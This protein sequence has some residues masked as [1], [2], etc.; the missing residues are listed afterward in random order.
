M[1][2]YK[3]EDNKWNAKVAMIESHMESN[4]V[5]DMAA[6]LQWNL[7]QGTNDTDN[8]KRYWSNI[9]NMFATVGN[10]PIRLGKDSLCFLRVTQ[11][12]VMRFVQEDKQVIPHTL[13]VNPMQA[14]RV[15][16]CAHA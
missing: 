3:M 11:F 10:S 16:T 9:T 15:K 14:H 2:D 13:M 7:T 1:A 6:V 5:G 12:M 4:D 8:R